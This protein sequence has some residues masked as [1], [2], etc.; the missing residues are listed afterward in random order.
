LSMKG[1]MLSMKGTTMDEE[2]WERYW[3]FQENKN[4]IEWVLL[5]KDTTSLNLRSLVSQ[6]SYSL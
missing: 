2:K 3:L 5:L 6:I 4:A 1:K